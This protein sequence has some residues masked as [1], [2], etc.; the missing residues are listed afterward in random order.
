MSRVN[1]DVAIFLISHSSSSNQNN[2]HNNRNDNTTLPL[3]TL[4]LA[5]LFCTCQRDENQSLEHARCQVKEANL[6]SNG[7]QTEGY[8]L[9]NLLLSKPSLRLASINLGSSQQYSKTLFVG[10][11]TL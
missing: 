9:A 4:K 3:K 5:H 2:N 6:E 11:N 1:A 7:W 8:Q 10:P